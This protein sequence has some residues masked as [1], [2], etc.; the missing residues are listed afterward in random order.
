MD[1]FGTLTD[2]WHNATTG[3]LTSSQR[4]DITQASVDE[5]TPCANGSVLPGCQ[6][7]YKQ[8]LGDVNKVAPDTGC[9]L[10][11]PVIGCL[12]HSWSNLFLVVGGSILFFFLLWTAVLTS[13]KRRF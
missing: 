10:N 9:V 2:F 4:A 11:V 12:A 8:I 5:Y 1:I 13:P 6:D 3:E 7:L